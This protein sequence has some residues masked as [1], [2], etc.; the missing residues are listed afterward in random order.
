MCTLTYKPFNKGFWIGHNRDEVPNRAPRD[1]PRFF[2]KNNAMLIAP[3]DSK[4][5]GTWFL[6]TLS[7]EH[8][9]ILNGAFVKHK[10]IPPYRQSRGLLPFQYLESGSLENFCSSFNF[11]GIEP[12]TMVVIKEGSVVE[13]RWDEEKLHQNHFDPKASH[14][15]SSATLYNPEIQKEREIWFKESD[16]FKQEKPSFEDL[17]H[18]HRF[19]GENWPNKAERIFSVRESGPSSI[20]LI[21]VQSINDNMVWRYED[22]VNQFVSTE[23]W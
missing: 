9:A 1:T 16:Y 22:F 3:L 8:I 20:A 17:F 15:W 11:E 5:G 23:K 6:S 19:G 10:H 21:S 2:E 14:I 13:L 12:F 7:G 18:F 4:S